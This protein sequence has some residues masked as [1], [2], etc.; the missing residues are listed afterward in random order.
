MKQRF[1]VTGMTCS[2]CSAHVEK[3]VRK[4]PG[5][6]DVAVNLL[7][8]NMTVTYDDK[9]VQAPGIIQAVKDAGYGA[10]IKGE[11]SGDQKKEDPAKLHAIEMR[12]RLIWSLIFMVPLLYLA[13]GNMLG[14]PLPDILSGTRRVMVNALTQLFLTIPILFLNRQY[15]TGGFRALWN[16]APNMDSL[17]AVGSSAAVVYSMYMLYRI[18]V[19]LGVG[20]IHL[21]HD[22][23]MDLYFESAGVILTLITLGKFLEARSKG[24]TSEAIEKLLSLAPK[25]AVV[26]R[27]GT[28]TEVPIEEVVVGDTVVMRTGKSIP[29][30]GE[31]IEGRGAVNESA[32][33]GESML[34]DKEKGDKV[35][36]STINQSGYFTFR[37]T[38]VGNDTTFAQI[39][40]LV[41]E[42]GASKAPIAKLADKVSGVFVPVV[43]AIAL[44][45]AVVWLIA[46]ATVGFA[47]SIG[48]AVLVISCPCALGLATPTAIMVGTGKGAELG[49][50]IK[51]AEALEIAHTVKTV[52]LD[53]TGTITQG[54]PQVTD[55]TALDQAR[56]KMT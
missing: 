51:S 13:M 15:F 26:L 19:A 8:N 28:E 22:F 35:I 1:E 17:I 36:G 33:T 49:I 24:K 50:L 21:A 4:V 55:V 47:I 38:K 45:S 12:K 2:A 43:M 53:K 10:Y 34:V 3:S 56:V 48:I 27:D 25:T 20:H 23:S 30:D 54:K 32:L 52:V 18:A 16:K 39:I 7:G 5:V 42:A 29:V 41:E 44:L 6:T 40:R 31:V 9:S 37:A 14:A 46:G 11:G